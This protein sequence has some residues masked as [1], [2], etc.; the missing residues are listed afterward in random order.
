MPRSISTTARMLGFAGLLPQ[1]I[2][3][4]MIATG[5][6][7]ALGALLAFGYA[8]L[9]V[10]FL[11]GVWWGLS[12]QHGHGQPRTA[13]IAVMPTLIG[14]ALMIARILGLRGDVALV[15]LGVVVMLTLV[16]DRIL[17]AEAQAPPGWMGLRIPLSLGLGAMTVLAGVI[18]PVDVAIV[19]SS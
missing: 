16:V 9:I 17:V 4:L 13:A 5:V 18:A 6:D 11:G 7:P 10:S 19:Y 15:M 2:A 14:F 12:M 3:L 8:L 1:L